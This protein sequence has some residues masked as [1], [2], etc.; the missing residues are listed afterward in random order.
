M[1]LSLRVTLT[2]IL[3]TVILVTVAALGYSSYRNASF[4]ADDLSEQ[5]FEQ[6]SLR[7]DHQI[8]DLL[9]SANTQSDLNKLLLKSGQYDVRDFRRLA[10]YWLTV[11][12]A[13]KR[14][15]RLSFGV[16]AT[17]E[18]SYVR[19]RPNGELAI[20]EL[21]KDPKT[22]QLGERS[23][24]PQEYPHGKPYYSNPDQED[25]DPRISP[26]YRAAKKSGRQT[27]SD[28]YVFFGTEGFADLPGT[29]CATPV[30][31][32]D[33]SLEGVLSASF[34]LYELSRYLKD[35]KVGKNGFAFVLEFR[36]DGSRRVIAHPNSEILMRAV[37]QQGKGR[38]R[39]LVPIADFEDQ[40]VA[41]F[42]KECDFPRD[43]H[44]RNLEGI[45]R[46]A[47][48][49]EGRS[50]FAGYHCLSTKVTP[51]WLICILIPED[52][53]LQ[54]VKASNRETILI[55]LAILLAA[56]FVSL[57]VSRQVAAPLEQLAK[58]TEGIGRLEVE[59]LPVVHSLV[60]EVDR[61]AVTMEET[62]TSL[63]SF[64][65]YV[66]TDLVRLLLSSGQEA[67][68]GGENRTV[69]IY[70]CDLADFTSISETLSPQG[71]VQLLSDYFD[72]FSGQILA[73]GGTVDKYVGD[74]IMAFWGAPVATPNHA[75]AAC[76]TAL[77]NQATL[78]ELR[79][80]WQAEGKP[81]LFA[82]IG[83]HMGEVVVG[84]IGS[85]ARLNYTVMGDAVN[86][87]SRLEG[88]N[89][90]YGTEILISEIVYLDTQAAVVAR[91]LDWVS[92]KGK[93]QA[94]LVYELLGL[95]GE[96]DKAG[97]EIVELS[98]EGLAR[99]RARDWAEAIRIFEQ[100][101]QARPD[102]VPAKMI[103]ARCRDY[104]ATPPPDG[105]DGV[106]HMY[107]K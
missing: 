68:L 50:Y 34:D 85:P 92:V 4:T 103:I 53:V 33:G 45:K 36:E 105:W 2:T 43:F 101:L 107:Q 90:Y 57:F 40:R 78:R 52:D 94:V 11:M 15:T 41:A 59:P 86:L 1:K 14:L 88:L 32:K 7:V 64:Q 81:L 74:A 98:R 79:R 71:L 93:T 102:D 6:T 54:R 56:I 82:R 65:K 84:N 31:R 51:D 62:R 100:V 13:Q 8:N 70:F 5:I 23:W 66:P 18:W 67:K 12:E 26:W 91:P 17:G 87:A 95:K 97:A 10:A 29:S 63:R 76:T 37:P 77:R 42:L 48:T 58:E 72:A 69:T 39:E 106:H 47:F 28:T 9:F 24:G 83:I 75:L 38:G 89:K 25:Q 3:L 60:T 46:V 96:V 80:K 22:G 55:G 30:Y 99:Y 27:W 44:P 49:H 73:S 104:E 20:G 35:L 19:R 61:L 21:R 16:E